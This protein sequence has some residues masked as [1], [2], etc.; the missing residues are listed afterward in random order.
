MLQDPS[1]VTNTLLYH[2]SLQLQSLAVTSTSPTTI[3]SASQPPQRFAP[4]PLAVTVNKFWFTSLAMSLVAALFAITVYPWLREYK[5]ASRFTTE[6]GVLM[7]EMRQRSLYKWGVPLIISSIPLLLEIAVILFLTGLSQLLSSLS[8]AVFLP[9]ATFLYVSLVFF[10]FTL[11]APMFF[12]TCPY[13][14]PT[15]FA[16]LYLSKALLWMLAF[17]FCVCIGAP[18]LL[19]AEIVATAFRCI[20]SWGQ[21]VDAWKIML[22]IRF[23]AFAAWLLSPVFGISMGRRFFGGEYWAY[24][25]RA[26]LADRD[27]NELY[28]STLSWARKFLPKK[29]HGDL[30]RCYD[31]L[32]RRIQFMTAVRW[33]AHALH[34]ESTGLILREGT[35]INPSL[36]KR[37]DKGF[38]DQYLGILKRTIPSTWPGDGKEEQ[39]W[40]PSL[41]LA[42]HTIAK[43]KLTSDDDFIHAYAETLL[44]FQHSQ[45]SDTATFVRELESDHPGT[46][47]PTVLLFDCSQSRHEILK[48]IGEDSCVS[49][50]TPP[51][52]LCALRRL[53]GHAVADT[54]TVPGAQGTDL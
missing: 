38:A 23:W 18:V 54:R 7:R 49:L 31:S 16:I 33:I 47:L 24:R 12:S 52:G 46:R 3:S 51:D 29:Y 22:S 28:A 13:K 41:L 34:T 48:G 27:K 21:T 30:M 36:L 20:P 53:E 11:S 15:S 10:G 42:L 1:D 8:Y 32:P 37:I 4:P 17:L 5:T 43:K 26:A 35:A 45:I 19:C 50:R 44:D 39:E 14:S 25:E 9:F 2:V 40:G 6:E